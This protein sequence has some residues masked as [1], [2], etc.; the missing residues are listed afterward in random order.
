MSLQFP[1]RALHAHPMAP[2]D[3]PDTFAPKVVS[4]ALSSTGQR[5]VSQCSNFELEVWIAV[6]ML[7]ET[8]ELRW[9]AVCGCWKRA[10][11]ATRW[12]FSD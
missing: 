8:C 2:A 4:S 3:M 5:A 7:A 11:P 6:G 10:I 12:G 1:H 9:M